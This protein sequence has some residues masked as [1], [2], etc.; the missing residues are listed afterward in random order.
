M[1]RII[2]KQEV[3][4]LKYLL[5]VILLGDELRTIRIQAYIHLT[6]K[7]NDFNTFTAYFTY[8]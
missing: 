1:E 4:R 2:V 5:K 6:L 7:A 3:K 8:L